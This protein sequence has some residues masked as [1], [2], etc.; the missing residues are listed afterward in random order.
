MNTAFPIYKIV[1]VGDQAV[2]KTSLIKRYCDDNF[3]MSHIGTVGIDFHSA[4]IRLDKDT[5]AIGVFWDVAGQERFASFRD[6]FYSGALAVGLVYDVTDPASFFSLQNWQREVTRYASGVPMTVIASKADQTAIVPTEEA[7]GW[8]DMLGYPF[9][10]VS[11]KTGHN[12]N[13]LFQTMARQ[14]DEYRQQLEQLADFTFRPR[15]GS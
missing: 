4:M 5:T 10:E 9:I 8:A 12:I 13:N 6:Q 1:F 11:A 3:K 7:Q 2:G 15:S 14:A